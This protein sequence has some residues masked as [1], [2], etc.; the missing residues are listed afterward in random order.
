MACED[1]TSSACSLPQ[2][3]VPPHSDWYR[4]PAEG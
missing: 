4:S 1:W 3:S 2:P